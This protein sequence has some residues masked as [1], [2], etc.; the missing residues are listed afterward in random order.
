VPNK[1]LVG[2]HG[3]DKKA[4]QET[5]KGTE[6]NATQT[7]AR[8]DRLAPIRFHIAPSLLEIMY[9]IRNGGSVKPCGLGELIPYQECSTPG[10]QP[11]IHSKMLMRSSK[12]HGN[13]RPMDILGTYLRH[14][15]SLQPILDKRR[16]LWR[17]LLTHSYWNWGDKTG[18]RGPLV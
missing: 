10:I 8:R 14:S 6:S 13:S 12:Q 4:R 3:T 16:Q 2:M 17:V 7:G 9:L 5:K 18:E 15:L 1:C 11:R